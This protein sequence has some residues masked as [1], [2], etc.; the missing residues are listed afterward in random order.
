MARGGKRGL[1]DVD[2]RTERGRFERLWI[3]MIRHLDIHLHFGADYR[4]TVRIHHVN[5]KRDGRL[6]LQNCRRFEPD[7]EVPI[8]HLLLSEHGQSAEQQYGGFHAHYS[9]WQPAGGG[10][11]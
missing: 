10:V 1:R 2:A 6:R 3:R 9:I 5:F 8:V 4:M 11:S 7:V